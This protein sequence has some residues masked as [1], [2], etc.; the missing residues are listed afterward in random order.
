[1]TRSP[2]KNGPRVSLFRLHSSN[3]TFGNIAEKIIKRSHNMTSND[4]AF[5]NLAFPHCAASFSIPMAW[6]VSLIGKV[7]KENRKK[8]AKNGGIKTILS[9]AK[10]WALFDLEAMVKRLWIPREKWKIN[11]QNKAHSTFVCVFVRLYPCHI[12]GPI[13]KPRGTPH[14]PGMTRKI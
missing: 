3:W 9:N 5:S 2:N 10:N 11:L 1:M 13:L 14:Q 12:F 6:R 8:I 7:K 4:P